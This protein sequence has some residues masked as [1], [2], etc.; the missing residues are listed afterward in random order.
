[1]N[2]GNRQQ[3]LQQALA[4]ARRDGRPS[5][6]HNYGGCYWVE[7]SP[8]APGPVAGLYGSDY[9]VVFPDGHYEPYDPTKGV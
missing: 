6:V 2:A 5:Y 7:R 4:N 8:P 1:M 3:A 9:N